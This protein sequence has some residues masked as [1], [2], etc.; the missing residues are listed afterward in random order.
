MFNTWP[1]VCLGPTS[2]V[3]AGEELTQDHTK[4]KT[5]DYSACPLSTE[6][7]PS[8]TAHLTLCW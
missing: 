1:L 5:S 6:N 3:L 8:T 4:A 7:I 2:G